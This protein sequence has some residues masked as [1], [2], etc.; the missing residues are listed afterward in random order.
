MSENVSVSVNRR[1]KPT[2]KEDLQE[3]VKE[4][5]LIVDCERPPNEPNEP[6]YLY[7]FHGFSIGSFYFIFYLIALGAYRTCTTIRSPSS[8]AQ[9]YRQ[10]GN[11][12]QRLRANYRL[13]S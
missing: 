1:R 3:L 7:S 10:E 5:N 6:T 11:G 9:K 4:V 8:S 12:S 13:S 2:T